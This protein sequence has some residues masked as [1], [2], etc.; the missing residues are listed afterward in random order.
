MFLGNLGDNVLSAEEL[1]A[2]LADEDEQKTPAASEETE[3]N[4]SE[5]H[6]SVDTTK[7]FA[8]RLA[9]EKAKV[10]NEERENIAKSLGYDSFEELQKSRERKRYEDAGLDPE[11][12]SPIVEQ[13]VQE[14]INNDPRM[15]E[16][17]QFRAQRVQEFGRQELA[18]I[19]KLTGGKIT[20]FEQLPPEVIDLW[21]K[22]GS[23]KS[24]YLELKGEELILETR[25]AQS[26]GS[27]G[28]LTEVTGNAGVP[29]TKRS[30]TVDEKKMWKFFNPN[31]TDEELNK[32]MVDK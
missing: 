11:D 1:D 3:Q 23:L 7:A 20:S 15:K 5:Q 26:K 17:E 12:V 2:L 27:T 31:M 21:K 24:A 19:S 16:L 28:H 6:K 22:K 13:L 10:V 29:T 14:R 9:E 8:R 32:V 30:L 18:E 25:G 4:S